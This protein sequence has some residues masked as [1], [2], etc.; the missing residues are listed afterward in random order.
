MIFGWEYTELKDIT[1]RWMV[2]VR[3]DECFLD[4]EGLFNG[5]VNDEEYKIFS[6]SV[7]GTFF[8]VLAFVVISLTWLRIWLRTAS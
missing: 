6:D 2:R 1:G 4:T 8:S 5:A 7:D 3:C